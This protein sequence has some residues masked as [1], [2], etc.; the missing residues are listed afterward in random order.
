VAARLVALGDDGVDAGRLHLARFIDRRRAGQQH[1]ARVLQRL[2][3]ARIRQAEV[4]ADDGRTRL[5][6]HVQHRIVV[7]EAFVDFA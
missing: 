1:D 3:A 4:E 2:D 5:Q 6:Q 7:E